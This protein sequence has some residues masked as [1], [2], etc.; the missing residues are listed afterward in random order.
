MSERTLD[1]QSE[2][3]LAGRAARK[4]IAAHHTDISLGGGKSKEK[5]ITEDSRKQAGPGA[6][7]GHVKVASIWSAG[8]CSRFLGGQLAARPERASEQARRKRQQ[9]AALQI[10]PDRHYPVILQLWDFDV[11]LGRS[12]TQCRGHLCTPSSGGRA[13]PSPN[14]PLP[15]Q[16]SDG[17]AT[18]N[19]HQMRRGELGASGL[20]TVGDVEHA[21][22]LSSSSAAPFIRPVRNAI[23]ASGLLLS[24]M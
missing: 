2:S 10:R 8:A 13:M 9:A 3:L 4:R 23:R 20:W 1:F 14:F 16:P 11:P 21:I 6:P 17:L 22:W 12:R 24:D 19:D 18:S 15:S 7:Q 5:A